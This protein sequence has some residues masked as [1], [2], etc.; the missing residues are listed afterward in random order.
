MNRKSRQK[1]N[2]EGNVS[3]TIRDFRASES[4]FL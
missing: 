2:N 3:S 1:R 4:G